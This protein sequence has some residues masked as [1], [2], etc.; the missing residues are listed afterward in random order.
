MGFREKVDELMTEF[1]QVRDAQQAGTTRWREHWR[2][3]RT[4]G[5]DRD[6]S[7][8]S[9]EKVALVSFGT[10]FGTSKKEF[11]G[12]EC[13]KALPS[14]G[15]KHLGFR[16]RGVAKVNRL[17]QAPTNHRTGRQLRNCSS[18]LFVLSYGH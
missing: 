11:L 14:R 13:L 4:D 2:A 16:R 8:M 9:S 1:D 17:V 5:D 3:L 12:C 7:A 6:K 10:Q 18:R 15:H